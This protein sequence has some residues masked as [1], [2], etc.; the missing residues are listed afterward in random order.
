[1]G[2]DVVLLPATEHLHQFLIHPLRCVSFTYLL[3]SHAVHPSA[4]GS[5]WLHPEST[6]YSR[7]CSYTDL[8]E[9][10]PGGNVS[11]N[12]FSTFAR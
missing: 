2:Y 5:R 1:M 6:P 7:I 9:L 10:H 3:R 4:T 11:M 12:C 8:A